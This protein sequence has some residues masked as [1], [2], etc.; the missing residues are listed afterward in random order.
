MDCNRNRNRRNHYHV[1]DWICALLHAVNRPGTIN[2]YRLNH[3]ISQIM[4]HHNQ[5]SNETDEYRR[6]LALNLSMERLGDNYRRVPDAVH[7]A[8]LAAQVLG[9]I[10]CLAL[11]W[12][13]IF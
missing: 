10:A 6:R 4:K 8:V 5:L 9:V 7:A 11:I 13:L 12:N 1:S 3:R 2:R